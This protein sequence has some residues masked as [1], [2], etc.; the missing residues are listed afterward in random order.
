MVEC[1]LAV[2]ASSAPEHVV[3]RQFAGIIPPL[4]E[5]R[6]HV[7]QRIQSPGRANFMGEWR[8]QM[9]AWCA[10]RSWPLGAG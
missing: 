6:T 3:Q 9:L 5:K 8:P 1:S 10:G 2:I 4:E 7:P